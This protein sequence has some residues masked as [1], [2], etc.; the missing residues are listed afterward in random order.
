MI[1][2]SYDGTPTLYIVP[3]PIGNL[4]DITIRALN[5]LKEVDLVLVMSVEPGFGGQS[6]I[7]SSL[8]KLDY[9]SNYKKDYGL[10]YIIEIDG[11]VSDKNAKAIIEHGGEALVAGSYVFKGNIKE[12]IERLRNI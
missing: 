8:D 11:G 3:T 2:K 10:S 4:E 6:F 7:E 1:Q 12:N 9:L 5:I